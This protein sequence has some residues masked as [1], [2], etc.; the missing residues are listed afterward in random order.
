VSVRKRTWNSPS[1]EPKEA[2][3]VD[4]VDQHGERH[5]KTFAKKRDADAHHAIVGT[6]VR[7]GTHTADSRSVTV[8]RAAEMWLESCEA[9]GLERA[10]MMAYRQRA[11]LHITPILGALRLSQLTVP[12]VRGFEDRLR[13]DGRSPAMVRNARRSLGGILADAQERG[14]VAQNVVYSLRKS[15]RSRR[16]DGNGKLKIGV[17]IPA[18]AE[19]RAIV[20]ALDTAAGRYRPLLLTAIFT[21]LRASELRGLRWH[22]VDLKRGELHVR[23]RADRYGKI[24]RPKSEAGERTVPLPPIVVTALREHRLACPRN[25]QDIVFTNTRDSI[26]HRNTIVELGFHPVQVA[27]GVVDRHGGAKYKGL[28]SLRHFYASWCIN[29]RVDG[30]LELPLKMVQARLGHASIQMTADVYGHLFPSG[31]DGA[32]LAAA[33]KAF[34]HG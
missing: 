32:E 2:W 26:E 5:I 22:D 6:A 30:G 28:H 12:V 17:N 13:R 16:A 14:L 25:D 15:R 34:L 10:S 24:G 1:G 3:V 19:M 31:D 21:G 4:Y 11:D 33:E 8:A 18:P 20:G 7:A 27:A 29:R 23:Q 9:A